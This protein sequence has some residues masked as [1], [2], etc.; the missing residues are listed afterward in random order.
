MR[1]TI[2][3]ARI[4]NNVGRARSQPSTRLCVAK[5]QRVDGTVASG[6][7]VSANSTAASP[8]RVSGFQ[9]VRVS[10]YEEIRSRRFGFR[11]SVTQSPSHPVTQLVRVV[12][13]LEGLE[14]LVGC[15]L[16]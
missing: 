11:F 15:L 13:T 5:P 12:R 16:G 9:G 8:A 3:R 14:V 1:G 2:V 10:G 6:E 4:S 7:A